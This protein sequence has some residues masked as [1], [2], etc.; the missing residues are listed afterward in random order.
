MPVENPM[1]RQPRS[2]FFEVNHMRY[3]VWTRVRCR[4]SVGTDVEMTWHDVLLFGIL[5]PR[6]ADKERLGQA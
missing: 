3:S 4:Y 6:R 5:L 2:A 1:F